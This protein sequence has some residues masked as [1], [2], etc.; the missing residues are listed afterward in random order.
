MNRFTHI[1]YGMNEIQLSKLQKSNLYQKLLLI[2]LLM[3]TTTRFSRDNDKIADK[4]Q[5]RRALIK[6][7]QTY[8]D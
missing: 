1:F 6:F 3:I 7:I 4:A 2:R 8:L 5:K